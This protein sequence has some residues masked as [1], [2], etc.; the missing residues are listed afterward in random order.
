MVRKAASTS[1]QCD[2]LRVENKAAK[3]RRRKDDQGRF[4]P[5]GTVDLALGNPHGIP[6][7]TDY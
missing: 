1:N 7:P 3:K 5:F 6:Q 2:S 4:E